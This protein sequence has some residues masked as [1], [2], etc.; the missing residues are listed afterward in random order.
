MSGI[1]CEVRL[2]IAFLAHNLVCVS[3]HGS[4]ITL[5]SGPSPVAE[6]G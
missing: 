1:Y 2:F 3:R 6:D 5:S 4:R